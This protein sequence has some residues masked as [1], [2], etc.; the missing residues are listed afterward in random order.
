ME[1][2]LDP[3]VNDLSA[4]I[5]GNHRVIMLRLLVGDSRGVGRGDCRDSS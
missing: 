5:T 1:T 3:C 2:T 4:S